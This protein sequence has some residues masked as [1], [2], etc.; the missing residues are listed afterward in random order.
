MEDIKLYPLKEED[1]REI[2]DSLNNDPEVN[3][4]V[5][6]CNS[7]D[8]NGVFF[9]NKLIG[10]FTL[11]KF[12]NDTLAIHIAL[13]KE[14]RNKKIGGK[15]LNKIVEEYGQTYPEVEFF[16]ANMNYENKI[17]IKVLSNLGWSR[18]YKYDEDMENEGGEF[19]IIYEKQNP[20]YNRKVMT[21]D[22]K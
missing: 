8:L 2:I 20:Y 4:F 10:L 21:Y 19:F 3:K 7:K 1:S 17:A 9:N 14:Y 15:V 13:I 22:T 12:I 6:F 5:K 11:N 18:T 16:L